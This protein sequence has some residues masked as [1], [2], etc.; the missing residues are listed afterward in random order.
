MVDRNVNKLQ[1]SFRIRVQKS[2]KL[3]GLK[4]INKKQKNIKQWLTLCEHF[5]EQHIFLTQP[6]LLCVGAVTLLPIYIFMRL[7]FVCI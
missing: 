7:N 6:T 3:N 1:Y 4:D 2:G 5:I